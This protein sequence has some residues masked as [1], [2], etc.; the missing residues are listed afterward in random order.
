MGIVRNQSIKNSISFYI[1]MAIGALNTIVIYPNTFNDNP[2]HLGLLQV[3]LAYSLVLSTFTTLGI[4]KTFMKY[5]PE[6]K[7]KGQLYFFAL[8]VPLL[9]FLLTSL[10]YFSFKENI[11]Q[12]MGTDSLLRENFFYII[13]LVFFI[14][15]Y[16]VLTSISRSF[17][18]AATPIF[19]NEV[20]LKI[21]SMSVLLLHWFDYLDFSIFLKIYLLGYVLKFLILFSVQ[22]FSKRFQFEFSFNNLK[23]KE[24]ITYGIYVLVGSTAVVIVA[25]VDMIM[26]ENLLD[27]EQVAYYT[28]AFF[29]GNAIMVPAKSIN[30]ISIP[31]IAK[32]WADQDIKKIHVIY[33]KSSINQLLIGGIFFL[34]IWVNIDHVFELLPK[35]FSSGKWVVFYI[36]LAQLFNISTGVNGAIIT[37]TKYYRF[38]LYTSV[39]LAIVTVLANL[40]LIP[41]FGIDGAAMATAISIFLFNLIRLLVV[42]FKLNIHPFSVKTIYTLV[43]LILFYFFLINIFDFMFFSELPFFNIVIKSF[44]TLGFFIPLLFFLKL[45]PDI[46]SFINEIINKF[47][48]KKSNIDNF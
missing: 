5:F 29:I 20:F 21:Y 44:I 34:C 15:F 24:L 22:F 17:L 30:A 35:K 47:L 1:G 33:S 36:G 37:N 12:L 26:I 6:I 23:L 32:A 16:D 25:R 14:G 38:D 31:L 9:G 39:L 27:L 45:S 19:I 18:S 42:K 8:I 4:P 7:Q 28:V 48:N 3:I 11:F 41:R 13:L 43:T 2:E 10:V 46:N 40:L